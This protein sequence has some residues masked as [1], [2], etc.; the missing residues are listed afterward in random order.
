MQKTVEVLLERNLLEVFNVV[1][2]MKRGEMI[3]E[4][5]SENCVFI[6]PEGVHRG[7]QELNEAAG[8]LFTQFPGYR[9]SVVSGVQAL[10][11]IGRLGWAYGP[12]DDPRRIRGEDIGVT[13]DGKISALYTFIDPPKDE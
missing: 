5:W 8:K 6:D 7:T 2:A 13:E 3:V 12:P 11:G 9:F 4:L 1:D 10:H